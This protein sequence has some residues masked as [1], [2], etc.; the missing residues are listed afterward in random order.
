[1]KFKNDG[2][3]K[4]LLILISLSFIITSA[5]CSSQAAEIYRVGTWKTAQTIQPFYYEE[6]LEDEIEILPFT[7]SWNV[8]IFIHSMH[9]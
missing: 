2:I 3:K 8:R 5:G 7:R 6:Y 9:R 1:M 4:I